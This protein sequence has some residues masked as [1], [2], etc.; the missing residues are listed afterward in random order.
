MAI[1][2][3][4]PSIIEKSLQPDIRI[5]MLTIVLD[6]WLYQGILLWIYVILIQRHRIQQ[7]KQS[8]LLPPGEP[9]PVYTVK[10]SKSTVRTLL[11][12]RLY[13]LKVRKHPASST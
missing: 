12:I 9:R 6:S 4:D 11:D 8:L 10:D 2:K 5:P 3:G 1:I 7:R 13:I